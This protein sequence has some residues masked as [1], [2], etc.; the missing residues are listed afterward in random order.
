MPCGLRI[1]HREQG[2]RHS[3]MGLAMN[4]GQAFEQVR[5]HRFDALLVDCRILEESGREGR[6]DEAPEQ[7]GQTLRGH[8][9]A[10]TRPPQALLEV[11]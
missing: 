9:R 11:E 5:Q 7:T 10:L 8:S 3:A 6:I 1:L 2:F 4:G